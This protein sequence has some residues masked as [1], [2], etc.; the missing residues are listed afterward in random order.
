MVKLAKLAHNPDKFDSRIILMLNE[1]LTYLNRNNEETLY[2]IEFINLLNQKSDF[3][4]YQEQQDCH[5]FLKML[6][7]ILDGKLKANAIDLTRS[8]NP[9]NTIHQQKVSNPFNG[10]F[11]QILQCIQC[12][13]KYHMKV[14]CFNDISL[15]IE[16]KNI[17]DIKTAFNHYFEPEFL[18]DVECLECS[19]KQ[20]IKKKEESL[21]N[22]EKRILKAE[23]K[24]QLANHLAQ[25]ITFLKGKKQK[26]VLD[27]EELTASL[28][29]LV[30]K[31]LS[32]HEEKGQAKEF[33][34][35]PYKKV[36]TTMKKFIR[37]V[38]LPKILCIHLNRVTTDRFGNLIK[39]DKHIAF[40]E[41]LKLGDWLDQK[42]FNEDAQ[43]EYQLSAVI[44]HY[45]TESFG[46]YITYRR[47]WHEKE[48]PLKEKNNKF[49]KTIWSYT[50]DDQTFV[51]TKEEVLSCPAYMLFYERV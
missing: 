1:I 33:L 7:G 42:L 51:V 41:E 14:E 29:H 22:L 3:N 2:P 18:E 44:R 13:H 27:Q 26:S 39:I 43:A 6:M 38:R 10:Y 47:A 32:E 15:S 48:Y 21:A 23:T 45:G 17:T 28:T 19:L 25:Q 49:M 31:Q 16:K 34:L 12:S 24:T 11:A 36:K 20:L 8:L 35:H 5:E 40:K 50:S 37:F 9:K 4:F 46:H 30:E